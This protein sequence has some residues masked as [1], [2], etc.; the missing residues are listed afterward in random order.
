MNLAGKS[1]E[2][3]SGFRHVNELLAN[4]RPVEPASPTS[5]AGS[6]C[7]RAALGHR[8]LLILRGHF[9]S[10]ASVRWSPD[11]TRLASPA[12][13]TGRC[14]SVDGRRQAAGRSWRAHG[15][16]V[17]AVAWSPD[18][19]RLA[20]GG[21]DGTV[22]LWAADGAP[23]PILKGRG[24]GSTPS[25]GAPTASG[26]PGGGDG[27]V[28]TSGTPSGGRRARPPPPGAAVRTL[29]WSP[30][31][32]WRP[33]ATT[34]W[35]ASG[36]SIRGEEAASS[37]P[38]GPDQTPWPG[39]QRRRAWPRPAGTRRSR[40]G[41]PTGAGRTAPCAGTPRWSPSPGARRGGAWPPP[42]RTGRSASGAPRTA[43]KSSSSGAHGPGPVGEL[44][45]RRRRAWPRRAGTR[46]S[47]SGRSNASP[48]DPPPVGRPPRAASRGVLSVAWSPDGS[49]LAALRRDGTVEVRRGG[50]GPHDPRPGPARG[51]RRRP[52][53]GV[54]PRRPRLAVADGDATVRAGRPRRPAAPR[55]WR[56]TRRRSGR[57]A[58]SPRRRD[59]GHRRRRPT[60]RVWDPDSG[61]GLVPL[62]GH[63]SPVAAVA[64]SPD[65]SRL[66]SGG[67]DL[68]VIVW[69]LAE[70]PGGCRAPC[71]GTSTPSAR[72]AGA[73]TGPPPASRRARRFETP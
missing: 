60:V 41:R 43:G 2:L 70:R 42:A 38:R 52:G 67:A 6:Y 44:G 47:R 19:K 49:R 34:P 55:A 5:A 10:V 73:P 58:W 51:R 45:P 36:T 32:T 27:S 12:S 23:G 39:A 33:R 11:G 69:D 46:R 71:G 22:R 63:S 4:W 57:R 30:D 16:S 31:S 35:C 37:R 50:H 13:W 53:A 1:A 56:A 61:E 7:P 14:G 54:E 65:G 25:P 64:W 15:D 8:D 40:S 17:H 24:G 18:G 72:S 28:R 21:Y 26:S 68:S 66:A 3:P 48:G 59:P 62:R 29:A 9:A 20:S